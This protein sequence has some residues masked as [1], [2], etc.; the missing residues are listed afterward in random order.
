MAEPKGESSSQP[1]VARFVLRF[2]TAGRAEAQ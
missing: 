2:I 1:A